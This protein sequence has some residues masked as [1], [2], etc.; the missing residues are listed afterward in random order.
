MPDLWFPGFC[1]GAGLDAIDG[2]RQN[3]LV[4]EVNSLLT[5]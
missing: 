2:A 4:W 3:F 1:I 5:G